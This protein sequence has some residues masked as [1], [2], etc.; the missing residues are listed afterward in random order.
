MHFSILNL[1]LSAIVDDS[2]I[3]NLIIARE[4]AIQ[5]ERDEIVRA[6]SEFSLQ[7][8]LGCNL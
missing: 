8:I 6:T 2:S 4:F 7:M 1:G 5:A 3:L